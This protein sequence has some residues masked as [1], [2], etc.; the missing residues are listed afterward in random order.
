M[1]RFPRRLLGR[2]L[3]AA[4]L[5]AYLLATGEQGIPDDHDWHASSTAVDATPLSPASHPLPGPVHPVHVCH[6]GHQHAVAPVHFVSAP[7][8]A[9]VFAKTVLTMP[10][11]PSAPPPHS[12][13]RPPI[14]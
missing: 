8:F 5:M 4:A 2:F 14:A 6:D 11:E 9:G 3:A 12:F 10:D 1:H 13:F 7:V